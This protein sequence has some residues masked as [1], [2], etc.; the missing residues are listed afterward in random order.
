[1]LASMWITMLKASVKSGG[2]LAEK[3]MPRISPKFYTELS[4]YYPHTFTGGY[5]HAF[6]FKNTIDSKRYEKPSKLSTRPTIYYYLIKE[7]L[8]KPY[9]REAL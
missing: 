6:F 2:E 1:M 3:F 4:D 8:F 7:P 9:T 5:P